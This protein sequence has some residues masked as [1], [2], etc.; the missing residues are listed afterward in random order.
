MRMKL[1]VSEP[2][3]DLSETGIEPSPGT[4]VACLLGVLLV[5][6]A[7]WAVC[8]KPFVASDPFVYSLGAYDIA[9]NG[10]FGESVFHHR[11]AVVL[12]VAL[13]YKLFGVNIVT[14]SVWAL[15]GALLTIIAVWIALPDSKSRV[16][17]SLLCLAS[18]PL[19][20]SAMVLFPDIIATPFMALS[21]VLLFARRR[22]CE[23]ARIGASAGVLAATLLFIAFFAKMSAYWVL[24]LWIIGAVEDMRDDRRAS[25]LR[26][27]YL[28]AAAAG[29]VLGAS[30]LVFCHVTWGDSFARFKVIQTISTSHQWSFEEVS[31]SAIL[32]RLTT[33]PVEFLYSQYSLLI[34]CLAFLGALIA[35]PALRPWV[36]YTA[37]CLGFFWFGSVSFTRWMPL[38]MKLRMVIPLLPGFY[39]LAAY[40]TSRLTVAGCR[41]ASIVTI[42]PVL[43]VLLLAGRRFASHGREWMAAELPDVQAMEIVKLEV[44]SNPQDKHLLVCADHVSPCSLGFYFEY[45]YPENLEVVYAGDLT[46]ESFLA[47]KCFLYI[48]RDLSE[49]WG[50]HH[51]RYRYD[52]AADRLGFAGLFEAGCVKLLAVSREDLNALPLDP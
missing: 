20:Q 43:L 5:Y 16:I 15:A 45:E 34:L 12:P 35:I 38:P 44:S 52:V 46:D 2:V 22:L 26:R 7:F 32:S 47:A 4:A 27:F 31:S 1:T 48:H 9:E 24:P 39:I 17:G 25:L 28:P 42:I 10:F 3:A 29:L 6:S 13:L 36:L 21:S 30:Y 19:F 11:L 37:V 23:T 14:T 40:M 49:W 51:G 33:T 41:K 18:V 50:D 8:P